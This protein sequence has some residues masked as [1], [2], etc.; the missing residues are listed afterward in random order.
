MTAKPSSSPVAWPLTPLQQGMLV[1][2]LREPR[3]GAYI[4][5]LAVRLAGPLDAE[6]LRSAW[7]AVL[8]RHDALRTGVQWQAGPQLQ[9][10]CAQE[11]ALPF[12][13]LDRSGSGPAEREAVRAQFLQEDRAA[14]FALDQPPLMRITLLRWSAQ[15]WEM[16]WSHHHAL[17]DGWSTALVLADVSAL[18]EA[19]ARGQQA[20]LPPAPSFRAF[21]DW[22]AERDQLAAQACWQQ[23][24]AGF[25]QPARLPA[26]KRRR[27][28]Q[29]ASPVLCFDAGLDAAQFAGLAGLARQAGVSPA[30]AVTACWGLLLGRHADSEDVV[31]GVTVAGR[32]AQLAGAE[33]TVGPF[34]N[35]IPLRLQ[36]PRAGSIAAWLQEAQQR[37]AAVREH[38]HAAL[39][40]IAQWSG[41][42]Q[43]LFDTVLAYEN[44][45]L[46]V[47]GKRLGEAR[48]ESFALHE[49]PS[50][51]L[52]LIAEP[53]VDGL[54]LR[55]LADPARVEADAARRMLD[56]LQHLLEQLA[57]CDIEAP[58]G[59][60]QLLRPRER[61][62]ILHEWNATA[63]PYDREATLP[64]MF[65][66]QAARTPDAIALIDAAGSM[67]YGDLV[68]RVAGVAARLRELALPPCS[69]V[70]VRMAR[71]RELVVALLAVTSAGHHYVPIEPQQPPAR[72]DAI[73]DALP[74]RC[75]L[76]QAALA[77]ATRE[78]AGGRTITVLETDRIAP[79]DGALRVDARPGDLAYVIFTSGS[80]GRPKGVLVKHTRAVNLVDWVNRSFAVGPRDRMLFVTSPAFDLSVYDVFGML[81]AGGSVR[82]A[83][84][85]E[86]ADPQRLVDLLTGGDITFWDSAPAALW[87]LAPLLPERATRSA[88]RLVF[89]SGDWIPLPLPERIRAV[90]PG[91]CVVALGG[92]T[93]ATVWSNFHVVGAVDPAW[94]S[95][96]YG[97]PIQNARYYVLDSG[98]QPCPV[99]VPGDLFIG[100]ECLAEGYAG[101]PELTAERFIPDAFVPSPQARM[102]R[103]GDR[104]RFGAD[105][106][107]EFLGRV[108]T[109]VKLRGFRI[110]LG[111]I[112]SALA[113]HPAVR[114]AVCVLHDSGEGGPASGK[115]QLQIVGYYVPRP[116]QHVDAE[117]LRAHLGSL[118]PAQMVPAFL[119]ALDAIPL[120]ANGKV[121]RKNL[122]A[123]ASQ[124]QDQRVPASGDAVRDTVAS[125]W[126]DVLGLGAVPQDGDFFALGGHSLR[127]TSA[128]ARLRAAFGID[129]PLRLIF[130]QPSV[131]G[132]AGAI[133]RLAPG[134]APLDTDRAAAI[135]LLDPAAGLPL[136]RAQLR[137]WF[138]RQL[139]P[140][141]ASY[142]VALAARIDGGFDLQSFCRAAAAVIGRHAVLN[143]IIGLRNGQPVMLPADPSLP[144]P[145]TSVDLRDLPTGQREEEALRRLTLAAR[146]PFALDRER[147]VRITLMV[148]GAGQAQVL[149]LMDHIATDGW[150]IGLFAAE[151]LAAYRGAAAPPEAGPQYADFSAWHDRLVGE[152]LLAGELAYWK[153]ALSGLQRLALK[154]DHARPAAPTGSGGRLHFALGAA[155][156]D[157]LRRTAHGHSATLFMLLLT[158]FEVVLRR[159]SGQEEI[160][161]GT[162]I[163]GRD[164][165]LAERL[166]GFFVNQLVLRTHFGA[167]RSFSDMLAQV[168]GRTL[169]AFFHQH[170]PFDT[171]VQE[172]NPMRERAVMPLFQHKFVLQNAPFGG[173]DGGPLRI[174]PLELETGTAKYDLLL[175][176]IDE[177]ALRGTL[178]YS[179]ELFAASTAQEM[180]R[181]F[182]AVL[183]QV[184]LDAHVSWESLRA[185]LDQEG[186]ARADLA[187]RELRRSG[188]QRLREL[189]RPGA[190]A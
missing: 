89:L 94:T 42:A 82:I 33:R 176:V 128:V 136:S 105:G 160:V 154:T 86:I 120:S 81:A 184:A 121:D 23:A 17:V 20:A 148:T 170:V 84:E 40:R 52:A 8:Q 141:S 65:A 29:D 129:I 14:G 97:R 122:P 62:T 103:T 151:L 172:I 168:R 186:E 90:F 76:S 54:S 134:A 166:Q 137:L 138:M 4:Q 30:I 46:T 99:G 69:P 161:V 61:E 118:L 63:R 119:L 31:V 147:P 19:A 155:L 6:A 87:Q 59:G 68:Q 26:L 53:Q 130:E 34:M 18:Y 21:L 27:D 83:S 92:A 66:A 56:Q 60:L 47:S 106:T 74:I 164:H 10:C 135:P 157:K 123:P 101:Q 3:G 25:E 124:A 162:D 180:V 167:C 169:E 152:S 110:E 113:R 150:S 104:A 57:T 73:L 144:A 126:C 91:A 182:Q 2:S 131:R 9:G 183:E 7:T 48:I 112:E 16:V 43:P 156:S 108:D 174:E 96:P 163:A 79:S 55:L 111:E 188:L 115:S 11:A 77:G 12:A 181:E 178:E 140:A 149:I 80:T 142:N 114:S 50:V 179:S 116:G 145:L 72:V 22:L 102:Y 38:E 75:I 189:A 24:L 133:R 143:T 132:M 45:P 49:R 15:E 85:G 171:L 35:T 1:H 88:L 51:P 67:T 70:G 41:L 58:P 44:Y 36:A 64:G 5:Q 159:R 139:E 175:T 127:A 95:V 173:L 71:N 125:V 13:V 117:Q 190:Q 32:P 28:A 187:R 185:M 98:L 177:P 146:T 109:Q 39:T 78:L 107:M 37:L 158:A 165:P 93:E 100:G 153:Q